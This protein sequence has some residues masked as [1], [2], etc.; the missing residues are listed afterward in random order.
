MK[1]NNIR[2]T[3]SVNMS[4]NGDS[5]DDI[6]TMMNRIFTVGGQKPVTQ[7]MMPKGGPIMPMVKTL[8]VVK[9]ADVD[10]G[11]MDQ[12]G[13]K[14]TVMKGGRDY[15][16][17]V[18]AN[19]PFM[20]AS[21]PSAPAVP[22]TKNAPA[23]APPMANPEMK[24]PSADS[25]DPIGDMIK[26]TDEEMNNM[27]KLAGLKHDAITDEESEEDKM[28]GNGSAKTFAPGTVPNP[29]SPAP[30]DTRSSYE[31]IAPTAL[32]GKDAPKATPPGE[33]LTSFQ[34]GAAGRAIA[35]QAATPAGQA[36][37]QAAGLNA[38]PAERDGPGPTP[39]PARPAPFVEPTK[40][41]PPDRA[42]APGAEHLPGGGVAKTSPPTATGAAI[43]MNEP[44]TDQNKMPAAAPKSNPTPAAGAAQPFK[45]TIGAGGKV[46]ADQLN[47][48]RQSTG[49]QNATLGQYMNAAQGKTAIAGGKN[50]PA[51]IQKNLG[52]GQTAY[53]PA[54]SK[55]TPEY[56]KAINRSEPT[57]GA[58]KP[59]ATS[60]LL[61]TS[62]SPRDRTRSRMPSSA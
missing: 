46:S 45:P 32:G 51:N 54:T 48:F 41:T 22:N 6:I 30:A 1:S 37:S 58:P 61:Y 50:D 39:A 60:C 3:V 36:Q 29:G 15:I 17:P 31:K 62:P 21:E 38:S 57:G 14:G 19:N 59:A 49:N 5:P 25:K 2:E 10:E 53:N 40:F 42:E 34:Q 11:P 16:D 20:R 7:D 33:P 28:V 47:Q 12:E 56:N 8:D 4:A 35:Q 52:A 26:S 24:L 13:T 43:G 44:D 18:T 23:A 55:G 27:R 9:N